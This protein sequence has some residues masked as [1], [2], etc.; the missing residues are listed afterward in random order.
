MDIQKLT[1]AI[2]VCGQIKHRDIATIAKLGF[3]TIINNRPDHEAPYQP[4]S[5]TLAARAKDAGLTYLYLPVISGKITQKDIEDFTILLT[6][7][8][9]P[10]L[11]FCRSGTRSATLWSK[12]NPD[13]LSP[14]EM[15]HI[16]LQAGYEL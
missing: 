6:K 2:S 1:A 15:T 5:K 4:R 3:K 13:N 7:A 12:V 10:I 9:G 14:D 11:A 8:R 16:G